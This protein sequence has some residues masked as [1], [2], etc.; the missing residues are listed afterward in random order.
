MVLVVLL[1]VP[2]YASASSYDLEHN[3]VSFTSPTRGG[4][5]NIKVGE[6]VYVSIYAKSN[7]GNPVS[8]AKFIVQDVNEDGI[9]ESIRADDMEFK[10]NKGGSSVL[11]ASW[12][13]MSTGNHTMTVLLWHFD[14][15]G[16]PLPLMEKATTVVQIYNTCA[17]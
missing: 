3:G 1:V 2:A 17:G 7:S 16:I 10:I 11:A 15:S 12:R 9:T 6:E 13:P 4:I 5:C 14:D 8:K